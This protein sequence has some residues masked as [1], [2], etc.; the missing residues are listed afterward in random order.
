MHVG[1]ERAPDFDMETRLSP[2]TRTLY[3]KAEIVLRR[4]AQT[5]FHVEVWRSFAPHVVASLAEA[6][7]GAAEW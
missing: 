4:R 5:S 7:R 6:A 1:R 2:A 3:E